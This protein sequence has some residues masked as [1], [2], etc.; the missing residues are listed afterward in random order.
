MDGSATFRIVLSTPMTTTH[1]ERTPS[2]HQRRAW[3]ASG[4]A[5]GAGSRGGDWRSAT[6]VRGALPGGRWYC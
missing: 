1:S 5:G 6:V 3:V 4:G 2:V